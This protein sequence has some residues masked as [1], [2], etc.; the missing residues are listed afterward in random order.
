MRSSLD[1]T[2][3]MWIVVSREP[4]ARRAP[5]GENARAYTS[6]Q[7]RRSTARHVPPE[8]SQSR[9]LPSTL[10]LASVRPS[11]LKRRRLTS[12]S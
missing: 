3:Q 7:W 1:S 11:G 2:S 6:S 4:V 9:A 10:A 12:A 5:S 8:T